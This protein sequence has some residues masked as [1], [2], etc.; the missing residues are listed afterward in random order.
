MVLRLGGALIRPSSF[1]QSPIE[2]SNMDMDFE[3]G[4]PDFSAGVDVLEA[5]LYRSAPS[6]VG[7]SMFF[8]EVRHL[9][10]GSTSRKL[11]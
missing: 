5:Y 2:S 10:L 6:Q 11:G 4:P 9:C 1:D 3:D 7:N 8:L